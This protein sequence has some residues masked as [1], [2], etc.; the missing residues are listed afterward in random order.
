MLNKFLTEEVL[1][2]CWHESAGMTWIC[3]KCYRDIG[4]MGKSND[5]AVAVETLNADY[6]NSWEAFGYLFEK[7]KGKDWW[8]TFIA[9]HSR[10]WEYDPYDYSR[11]PLRLIGP[12]E[13]AREIAFFHGWEDQA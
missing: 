3:G 8:Q 6:C 7:C 4:W 11:I 10:E 13:F 9:T 1:G 2:E 12:K 5:E